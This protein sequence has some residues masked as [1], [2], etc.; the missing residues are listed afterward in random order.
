[1]VVFET[2]NVVLLLPFAVGSPARV[3]AQ[4]GQVTEALTRV[5]E[6][7]LI[8]VEDLTEEECGRSISITRDW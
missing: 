2:G 4:F 6:S 8:N 1:M 3:A 7:R 5:R